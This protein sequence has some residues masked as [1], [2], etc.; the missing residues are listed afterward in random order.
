MTTLT[1]FELS[2]LAKQLEGEDPLLCMLRAQIPAAQVLHRR[3]SG[4]GFF[5]TVCVPERLAV[6]G[7]GRAQL[8]DVAAD[9]ESLVHG[10]GFVLFIENGRIS[11]LE[12]FTFDEPWPQGDIGPFQLRFTQAPRDLHEVR[13][14]LRGEE[15]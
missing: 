5:T 10:A 7:I 12:G 11:L 13:R 4:V 9:I 1:N 15:V 14:R 8:N 2:I 6:S 3:W